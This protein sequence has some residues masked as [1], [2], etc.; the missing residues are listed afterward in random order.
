VT[1]SPGVYTDAGGLTTMFNG[2]AGT[3]CRG[4]SF[5]FPP[6]IY[7]FDFTGA[8]PASNE[9][10]ISDAN[11]YIVAGDKTSW[12]TTPPIPGGCLFTS[13][14]AGTTFVF[15]HGS[16][17]NVDK[18]HFEM[19]A[20]TGSQRIAIA[21]D[22][23]QSGKIFKSG[24]KATVMIRGTV[25]APKGDVEVKSSKSIVP[26]LTR[27]VVA[28]SVKIQANVYN[29]QVVQLPTDAAHA[30][31]DATLQLEASIGSGVVVDA[32]VILHHDAS[33]GIVTVTTTSW[34]VRV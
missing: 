34:E 20:P 11:A 24:D 13:S 12:T 18:G 21:G 23:T 7:R 27:G 6:G 25:Y 19:C 16:R 5:V 14:S 33:T 10:K 28:R 26:V 31:T 3:P 29:V 15:G 17:L 30:K 22:S 2:K 4:K 9:W 1:F 32:E 8:G